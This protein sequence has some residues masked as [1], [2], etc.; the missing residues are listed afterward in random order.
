MKFS[1][2]V[3][4][5]QYEKFLSLAKEL[6]VN[7]AEDSSASTEKDWFVPITLIRERPSEHD[8]WS[9]ELALH[10]S[11]ETAEY[12]NSLEGSAASSYCKQLLLS[13]IQEWLT[14]PA[15]WAAINEA[16]QDFNWGD[17][18]M[19]SMPYKEH[20]IFMDPVLSS[21]NL[22]HSVKVIV[23]QDELLAPSSVSANWTAYKNGVPQCVGYVTV[24]FQDGNIYG[25]V[26]EKYK[27]GYDC[28]VSF[29]AGRDTIAC[30]PAE[31][32]M[33]LAVPK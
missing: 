22:T 23:D 19:C 14:T 29:G 8:I 13:R 25:D 4:Q 26:P 21:K 33:R 1:V 6:G 32:N 10:V 31:Y 24:D 7:V 30:D 2:D 18:V 9:D 15:G 11:K 28:F 27:F 16:S 20:G 12:I 3:T 17:F 5:E